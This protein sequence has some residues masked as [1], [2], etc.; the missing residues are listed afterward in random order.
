METKKINLKNEIEAEIFIN[1]LKENNIP[2][3]LI[4]NHSIVY[5]G[6]FAMQKGWGFVEVPIEY[7]KQALKLY[8]DFNDSEVSKGD[9]KI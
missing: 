5:D 9:D 3:A 1:I 8:K 4:S 2:N 6:I 7:Y